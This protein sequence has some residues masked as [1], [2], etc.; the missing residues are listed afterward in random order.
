MA[1]TIGIP[2]YNAEEY[3]ADAI[4][5]VFAQTYQEWELILVNDGSTDRSLEIARSVKDARVRVISDGLNKRLPYR[6]NQ[7]TAEA[8]YEMVG[9][10]DADD[11]ISPK[12]FEIQKKVM[13]ERPDCDIVS[14]G[15]CSITN[16]KRPVGVRSTPPETLI[17]GRKLLLGQCTPAHA[18]ILGRTSWFKR[19]AYDASIN[20]IED[21]EL[22]LRAYSKNDFN[23]CFI[24]DPLYYYREEINVTPQRMLTA[25][26]GQRKMYLR[27]GHIGF[28]RFEIPVQILKLYGKSFVVRSLHSLNKLDILLRNRNQKITDQDYLKTFDQEIEIILRTKVPG[29]D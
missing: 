28:S 8:K 20:R 11:L 2:F 25:Y 9:R 21:Y 16:D 12:K 23:V 1:I 26:A 6:L 29:L 4:R 10:M 18:T 19:N 17:T 27:Y 7:I 5:S 3:L 22:W 13:D 14:T 24:N 15:I